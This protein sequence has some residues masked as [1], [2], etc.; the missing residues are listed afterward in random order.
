[1]AMVR[2]GGS[3]G[4]RQIL[5]DGNPVMRW[6]AANLVVTES[7]MGDIKP[8]KNKSKEKIDGIVALVMALDRITRHDSGGPSVY[9]ERGIRT[10]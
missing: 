1:M 4:D 8:A 10:L 3:G 6:M 9:R 5:H 2:A 7:P